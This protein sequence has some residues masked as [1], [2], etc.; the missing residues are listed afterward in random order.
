M[1]NLDKCLIM[2]MFTYAIYSLPVF[3]IFY[4]QS[5]NAQ[6]STSLDDLKQQ[7]ILLQKKIELIEKAQKATVKSASIISAEKYS[8]PSP[9][10]NDLRV[11]ATV[12]PTFGYI[13]ENGETLMDVRD[14]LSHTGFKATSSFDEDWSAVLH[15]EWG[16]DLSGNGD[17]GKARQVYV[18]INSPIGSIGIGKQRPAQYLFIAEYVDIFNHSNSPF[19]YDPESMFF[20]NNLI[21]Y[22][23]KTGDISWML[24]SQFNGSEGNNNSDLTN[25][26][27]SYD[28]GPIHTAF[29][30]LIQDLHFE[31]VKEGED[32]IFAGSLAYEFNNSLYLAIGYQN[33]IYQRNSEP[34]DRDGHT[35]DLSASYRLSEIFKL[36]IG[37]FDFSDG[38]N[39]TQSQDFNGYNTTLEWLPTRSLRLH[40]EYLHRNF[41]YLYD[42]SSISIGF[43]YDFS[44][45]TRY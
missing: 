20:V 36:K 25:I 31:G 40:I 6:S 26:G 37:V 38:Y 23:L 11:Y 4:C 3:F 29:T 43:R 15:G 10:T 44:L 7:I 34:Y 42:F 12:R 21:T 39:N 22:K 30:Y 41:N 18:A 1:C 28:K 13:D 19:S 17:F 5:T 27:I 45:E 35:I 16:I 32:E 14:A 33:R 2:G 9:K 24:A 8:K